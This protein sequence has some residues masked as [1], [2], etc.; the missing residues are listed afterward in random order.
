MQSATPIRLV[1]G[2]GATRQHGPIAAL[3]PCGLT[4]ARI[5]PNKRVVADY[6]S[7]CVC[8]IAVRFR[9]KSHRMVWNLALIASIWRSS[10]LIAGIGSET[11]PKHPGSGVDGGA[12][13]RLSESNNA[14]SISGKL[15]SGLASAAAALP[16]CGLAL[17]WIPPLWPSPPRDT[18]GWV[19][20]ACL[21][22]P[23]LLALRVSLNLVAVP[24]SMLPTR[25]TLASRPPEGAAAGSR[26]K[27]AIECIGDV[28]PSISRSLLKVDEDH[29]SDT[30]F[31][32]KV[33]Q[34]LVKAFA[35]HC[36]GVR[37]RRRAKAEHSSRSS[38]HRTP[39]VG[40]MSTSKTAAAEA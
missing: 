11:C 24:V 38:E 19:A 12:S 10:L 37:E 23:P 9:I 34:R 20:A 1:S 40:C 4:R 28:V 36:C 14:Y 5:R 29:N 30:A 22:D 21:L 16:E 15:E 26:C 6:P 31:D 13:A 17:Q 33:A 32:T 18:R 35:R 7:G 27:G 39:R 8:R 2:R 25:D 3:H